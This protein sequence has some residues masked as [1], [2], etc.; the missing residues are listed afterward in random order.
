MLRPPVC[1]LSFVCRV[2]YGCGDKCRF[3]ELGQIAS[4]KSSSFGTANALQ[5]LFGVNVD[6]GL[7]SRC[8]M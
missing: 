4:L 8:C 5:N 3:E 6:T 2:L 7:E 1:E